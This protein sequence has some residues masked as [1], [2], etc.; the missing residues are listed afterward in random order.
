MLNFTTLIPFYNK[1]FLK[2][3]MTLVQDLQLFIRR[4]SFIQ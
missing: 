3:E 4:G 1:D 2:E